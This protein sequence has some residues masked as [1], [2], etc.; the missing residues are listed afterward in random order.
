MPLTHLPDGTEIAEV[1]IANGGSSARLMTYGAILVDFRR[2]GGPSLVL[3]SDDIEAYLGPMLYFG[4][5][6][7]PV[8]NRLAE[9]RAPLG[10]RVLQ[11]TPNEGENTL[12][13]GPKGSGQRIWTIAEQDE[14][15]V[16]FTLT[17][18]DGDSGFPGP[19]EMGA[20][21][22]IDEN[23]DLHITLTGQ[24]AAETIFNPA[25]H[26]YW[27]LDASPDLSGHRMTIHA[28]HY[29][30]T[31]DALIPVGPPVPV[32]GTDY[33]FR[34]PRGVPPEGILDTNFCLEGTGVREVARIEG[35]N[36]VMTIHTDAPG[37]QVFD[38]HP[39]DTSPHKGHLGA[40]YGPFCGLALEPQLWPDAPNHEGYPSIRLAPGESFTQ[41]SIFRFTDKA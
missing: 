13:G 17:W 4:A 41:T 21:Y 28:G 15:S 11:I 10:D 32:E 1:T 8:A 36:T 2:G 38:A 34:Q 27:N 18:P 30:A 5:V 9:G 19:I 29:T 40:P 20:T 3:G 7:G 35:Q 37:L 22:A 23:G 33:D 16:R 24:S 25:F 6:V 12:H 31:D 14:S 26:G 39:M